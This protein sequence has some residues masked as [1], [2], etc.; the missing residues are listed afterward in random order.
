M[1]SEPVPDFQSE[2]TVNS[3]ISA[4]ENASLGLHNH[5]DQGTSSL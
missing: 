1:E 5:K 4:R 2:E 3:E